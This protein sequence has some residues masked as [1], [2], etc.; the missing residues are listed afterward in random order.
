MMQ[1]AQRRKHEPVANNYSNV[2][3]LTELLRRQALQS[4]STVIKEKGQE[5]AV[6]EIV[7]DV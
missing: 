5:K 4:R 7:L 1:V 3:I 2:T 6:W